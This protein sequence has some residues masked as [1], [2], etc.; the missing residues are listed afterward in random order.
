VRGEQ[1]PEPLQG[2]AKDHLAGSPQFGD[3][4]GR[5]LLE[6]GDPF[7]QGVRPLPPGQVELHGIAPDLGPGLLQESP[8]PKS[9]S[10]IMA[11]TA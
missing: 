11:S 4:V 8:G 10:S 7:P 3:P 5:E 6:L 9:S 2:E 1:D